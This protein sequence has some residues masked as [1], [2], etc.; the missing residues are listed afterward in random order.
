MLKR[1]FEGNQ[2]PIIFSKEQERLERA[3]NVYF[4]VRHYL[5]IIMV[6]LC[7][8]SIIFNIGRL[9]LGYA[10]NDSVW[11]IILGCT[12]STLVFYGIIMFIINVF[13]T[14]LLLLYFRIKQFFGK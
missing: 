3:G 4:K 2:P 12:I 14:R 10:P 1:G 13:G 11:T 6:V 7:L 8:L 9:V 5:R